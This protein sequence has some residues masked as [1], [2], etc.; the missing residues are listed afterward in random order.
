MTAMQ[1][2]VA[3]RNKLALEQTDIIAKKVDWDLKTMQA[4]LMFLKAEHAMIGKVGW[5][6]TKG[7]G[8]SLLATAISLFPGTAPFIAAWGIRGWRA[9]EA[10]KFVYEYWEMLK[11]AP[12]L[13]KVYELR[14]AAKKA[15]KLWSDYLETEIRSYDAKLQQMKTEIN[16]MRTNLDNLWKTRE[17][18]YQDCLSRGALPP[19]TWHRPAPDYDFDSEGNIIG[20]L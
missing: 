15:A 5:A 1:Q 8:W 17:D 13:P 18:A 19:G 11:K 9:Y 12:D 6:I 7:I 20:V 10:G 14:N 3:E 4:D 2:K 16:Q